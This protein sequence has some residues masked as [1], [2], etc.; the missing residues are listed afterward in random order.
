MLILK[1]NLTLFKINQITSNR[2]VRSAPLK[3]RSRSAKRRFCASKNEEDGK[4]RNRSGTRGKSSI[5][6]RTMDIVT[7]VS[8]VSSADSDSDIENSLRDDK[9]IDELRSKLPTTS[10]IKTSINSA[11][12][13]A[14]RPI[15][16]GINIYIYIYTSMLF[17]SKKK[18]KFDF[19]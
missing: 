5:D 9:L 12:S 2:S 17:I 18:K 8:L 7:M 10:I 11:L 3:R 14:R 4:I 6:S 13:S 19:F 15:K 1:E 16:S